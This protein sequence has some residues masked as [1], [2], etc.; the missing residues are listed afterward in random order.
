MMTISQFGN[1]DWPG[2]W[3]MLRPVIR[4]ADTYALPADLDEAGARAYWCGPDRAV[5]VARIGDKVVG[6]YS[7]RANQ[8]GPG[9]HVAN[10]GYVVSAEHRGQGI[11]QALCA[12]S[13]E[14]AT[15]QGFR[16][17]QFNFVVSSNMRAVRLWQHMGFEILAT[18]PGVFAHPALGY[19]DAYV[20]F[21]T[22]D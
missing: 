12:H 19:I 4:A 6:S 22:L 8:R 11:A 15:A 3:A 17:M 9:S 10:A 5:W 13:L 16:A 2:M 14:T 20:M 7:L 18:L 21:R 1:A